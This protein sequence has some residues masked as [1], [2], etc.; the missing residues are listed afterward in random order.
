MQPLAWWEFAD[1]FAYAEQEGFGLH[2]LHD[3]G[4]PSVGD[5]HS[6]VPIPR[7]EWFEYGKERAGRFQG[8]KNADGSSKTECGEFAGLFAAQGS[9][10]LYFIGACEAVDRLPAFIPAEHRCITV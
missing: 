6:T 2:P 4:F 3:K 7:D 8:L 5:V 1:C 9:S 10:V